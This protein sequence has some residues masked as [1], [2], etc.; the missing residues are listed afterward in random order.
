[1]GSSQNFK[2]IFLWEFQD[3]LNKKQPGQQT[4]QQTNKQTYNI[5]QSNFIILNISA[6]SSRIFTKFSGE[7]SVGVPLWLKQKNKQIYKNKQTHKQIKLF[8]S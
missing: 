8:R 1:M 6:I 3:Y 4:N 2:G 5:L 7:L